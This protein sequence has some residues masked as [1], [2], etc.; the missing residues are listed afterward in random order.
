MRYYQSVGQAARLRKLA[1]RKCEIEVEKGGDEQQAQ[2]VQEA[3]DA[4]PD[5]LRTYDFKCLY[6][7]ALHAAW[8]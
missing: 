4:A 8:R 2:S 7:D 1:Q 3:R 5:A 6:R